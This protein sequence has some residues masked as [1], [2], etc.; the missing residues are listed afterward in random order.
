MIKRY[1]RIKN[2]FLFLVASSSF[3]FTSSLVFAQKDKNKI[4][5]KGKKQESGQKVIAADLSNNEKKKLLCHIPLTLGENENKQN[6]FFCCMG[7]MRYITRWTLL[8]VLEREDIEQHSCEVARIAHALAI[9]KNKKY[10]GH[11]NVEK[12]LLFS[13]YHDAQE[14]STSDFPNPVKYFNDPLTNHLKQIDNIVSENFLTLIKD[15]EIREEFKDAFITKKSDKEIW[16]IV[17]IADILSAMIKCLREKDLGNND[18]NKAYGEIYNKVIMLE[19]PEA[20]YFIKTFMPS[21]NMPL[22]KD[23]SYPPFL[24]K[25]K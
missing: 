23:Y 20:K 17:K 18:F 12:V 16:R 1:F 14:I 3:I 24:E 21:F 19:E 22:P 15:E 11:V 9:I 7:R 25:K 5:T 4:K 8:R 10:G 6:A 13:L 2:N